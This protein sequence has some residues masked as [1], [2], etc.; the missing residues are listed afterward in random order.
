MR[1]SNVDKIGERSISDRQF[2]EYEAKRVNEITP[3]YT[4]KAIYG[5]E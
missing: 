4:G 1:Q 5:N 3:D 2:T